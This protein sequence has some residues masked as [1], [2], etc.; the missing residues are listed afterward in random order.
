MAKQASID[1][2]ATPRQRLSENFEMSPRL[3]RIHQ[4]KISPFCD[5]IRRVLHVKGEP[6]EIVEIPVSGALSVRELNPSGKLPVLEHGGRFVSDSTDIAHYL[7]E[8]F[9]EP[10]LVPSDPHER[11]LCH[12]LEDWADESLYFYE[13]TLR[14]TRPHNA[15]RFTP[16]LLASD[17][18][19]AQRLIAPAIPWM[20]RR[21]TRGQGVGRKSDAE[22]ERDVERH[23][24]ALA[25][26]L[27]DEEWLVGRALSLADL[28]VYAQLSCIAL[29]DEGAKIVAAHPTVAA[30]LARVDAAS[31]PR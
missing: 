11:G 27:G 22:L 6:Y 15:A 16:D 31:Q 21:T 26:L 13:M 8:E 20:M 18:P 28:S 17:P 19:W 29:T 24:A 5:K 30:W 14:F 10:P 9:P 4:F 23:V 2:A 12:V 7:E 3:I 1:E 25:G